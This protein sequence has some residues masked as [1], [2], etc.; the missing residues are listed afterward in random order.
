MAAGYLAA[1]AV[2]VYAIVDP[3]VTYGS[4]VADILVLAALA[5]VHVATGWLAGRWW[6]VILPAL[7]VPIAVPAGYA[8][9][10]EDLLVWHALAYVV[11]PLG[12]A[13]VALGVGA[14]VVGPPWWRAGQS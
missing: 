6:A 8:E 7:V 9:R 11:A 10:T 12:A 5:V 13:L 14:R 1:M 4:G 3:S 2:Y